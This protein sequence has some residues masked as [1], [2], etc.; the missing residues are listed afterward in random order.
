[1][2]S[3]ARKR[4]AN[5]F[6]GRLYAANLHRKK[7]IHFKHEI[8]N[9]KILHFDLVAKAPGDSALGP[10]SLESPFDADVNM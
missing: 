4:D 5:V 2:I 10:K 3:L 1:M 8:A 9:A 6:T 7:V